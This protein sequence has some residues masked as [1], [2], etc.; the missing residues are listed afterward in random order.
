M[1]VEFEA[2]VQAAMTELGPGLNTH[3][4]GARVHC[5]DFPGCEWVVEGLD[6]R[7]P[8]MVERREDTGE[9]RVFV[10]LRNLERS[11]QDLA[12]M[13]AEL[14]K[15]LEREIEQMVGPATKVSRSVL[16]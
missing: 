16:N 6:P 10:Y 3:L 4:R 1:Q 12:G 2:I 5:V 11:A 14:T 15:A 8:V 7:T 9:V 13:Q